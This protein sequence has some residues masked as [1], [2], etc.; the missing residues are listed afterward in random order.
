MKYH[1]HTLL[2]TKVLR[3]PGGGW[4]EKTRSTVCSPRIQYAKLLI[5]ITIYS[6][7]IIIALGYAV[8]WLVEALCY[9]PEGRGFE[10]Q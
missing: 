4:K 7:A 6:I 10:S 3:T 8:A 5:Y 2:L 9:K 1:V